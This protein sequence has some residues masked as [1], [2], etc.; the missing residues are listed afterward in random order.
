MALSDALMVNLS[1][2]TKR[3]PITIPSNAG[4]GSTPQT[5]AGVNY[6]VATDGGVLAW[7]ID[8]FQPGVVTARNDFFV[9][10]DT[11]AGS[12]ALNGKYVGVGTE[13]I[14][15]AGGDI[16]VVGLRSATAATV[17]ALLI[18]DLGPA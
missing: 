9:A 14:D 15:N 4:A 1:V 18:L 10:N 8:A 6:V 12:F 2:R 11:V 3:I 17:T 7:R 16:G 13:F 5:L